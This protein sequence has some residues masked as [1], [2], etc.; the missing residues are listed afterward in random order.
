[1]NCLFISQPLL[2]EESGKDD[3]FSLGLVLMG[4]ITGKRP[5]AIYLVSWKALAP[6]MLSSIPL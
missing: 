1:M 5:F 6:Q 2:Q 3:L 4:M